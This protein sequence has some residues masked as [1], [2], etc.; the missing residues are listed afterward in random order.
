MVH[1][2]LGLAGPGSH[3]HYQGMPSANGR[4]AGR[5]PLLET[6]LLSSLWSSLGSYKPED[7]GDMKLLVNESWVRTYIAHVI[8]V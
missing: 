4:L 2:L 5:S 7:G 8:T 1:V 6:M 3:H